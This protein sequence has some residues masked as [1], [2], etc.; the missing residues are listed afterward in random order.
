M[1]E[2][3]DPVEEAK[4]RKDL[5]VKIKGL[6]AIYGKDLLECVKILRDV[7]NTALKN[8]LEAESVSS[9]KSD[10]RSSQRISVTDLDIKIL[11]KII[12]GTHDFMEF[13]ATLDTLL[14]DIHYIKTRSISQLSP[15]LRI[16]LLEA[17]AKLQEIKTLYWTV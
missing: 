12:E 5:E 13:G 10:R 4:I 11:E 9:D 14:M 6:L 8:A 3:L 2:L 15:E 1:E 16:S 7:K 17:E